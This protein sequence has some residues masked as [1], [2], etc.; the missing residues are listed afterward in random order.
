MKNGINNLGKNRLGKLEQ[1]FLSYAQL[2]RLT[3]VRYG[4]WRS[5]LALDALQEKKVLSRLAR[6]GVIVRLKRGLYLFP[7]R[8]PVGGVWNPGEYIVLRELMKAC[9]NGRYQF[10]GWSVFNRYGF[11]E[12][13][14]TRVYAYNNR[15]SGD[16]TIGG[17]EFTF[18]KVSDDRLGATVKSQAPDGAEIVLPTKARALMDAVY[19]W[20][21]F[22]SLPAAY[23]WIRQTV[24]ADRRLAGQLVQTTCRYGNQGTIRRIGYL[25]D[26][27]CPRSAWRGCM[28]K[29]LRQS[30]SLIPLVPGRPARGSV[31]RDWGVV[32]NE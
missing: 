7:P 27:L 4:E 6:A 23:T 32:V 31:N 17:Q 18:I 19:D 5:V 13:V 25:L 20:S 10:C 16:R 26:E 11:T 14:P 21:R 28:R 29:S 9:G 30:P 3:T 1:R 12:Q 22:A 2:K 24:R 8:L 15:L